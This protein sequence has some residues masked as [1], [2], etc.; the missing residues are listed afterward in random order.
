ME[1]IHHKVEIIQN[2]MEIIQKVEMSSENNSEWNIVS[3]LALIS[4]AIFGWLKPL[5]NVLVDESS[6]KFEL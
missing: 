3:V 1:I 2:K 4:A 5:T 6:E